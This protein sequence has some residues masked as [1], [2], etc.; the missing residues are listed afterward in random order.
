TLFRSDFV[1]FSNTAKSQTHISL[2]CNAYSISNLVLSAN[3]LYK[4][5][6]LV[7]ACFS[8]ITS[9]T[10][11]TTSL[12]I[13]S[14]SQINSCLFI[15]LTLSI[16]QSLNCIL[17]FQIY[18]LIIHSLNF[19]FIAPFSSFSLFVFSVKNFHYFNPLLI[20]CCSINSFDDIKIKKDRSLLLKYK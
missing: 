18:Y 9:F 2:S 14:Q 17:A 8:G 6:K 11:S 12:C 19:Y 3:A 20:I 1:I 15:F 13:T 10:F 4:L 7:I 5:V 16:E